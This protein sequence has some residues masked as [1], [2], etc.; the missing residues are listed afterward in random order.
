M[1]FLQDRPAMRR[2]TIGLIGLVV[3]LGGVY[4]WAFTALD[5]S[6]AARAFVWLQADVDDWRRFP[7]RT[8]AASTSPV[9]FP[10]GATPSAVTEYDVE[11]RPLAEFLERTGTTAFLVLLGD[12]LVYEEYFNGSSHEATQTSFSVAK[13]FASTLVGIAIA[14]GHISSLEDPVTDYIPELLDRDTRFGEI[15]LRHLVSMSSGIHYREYATPWSDDTATYYSPD[16]RSAAL[17]STIDEP[18]GTSFLYCNFNPLLIG[19]VLERATGMPVARYL[20]TRLWQPMGAEAD[21][22]W[23]L[24]SEWSGFEKMESGINGRAVDFL[25]LGWIFLRGGRNG[26]EQVVPGDWVEQAT[27]LDTK[28][29][30]A[31]Q[32]QYFWWVDEGRDAFYAEGNHGQFVYVSP[33]ADAVLVRMGRR[34]GYEDWEGVLGELAARLSEG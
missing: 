16:L 8:V 9:A 2:I 6:A 5:T 28:T 13:S 21:G 31:P 22:S 11:G 17:S 1:A 15:T 20:E 26:A 14:E 33:A 12:E 10:H 25:K 34:Y 18:P 30:P 7:E 23:S 24:D 19:M 3:L 27:R 4:A 32:Y 29:D